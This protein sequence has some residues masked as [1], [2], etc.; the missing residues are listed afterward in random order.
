MLFGLSLGLIVALAV[1]IGRPPV[2]SADVAEPVGA[3]APAPRSS[4]PVVKQSAPAESRFD[5]YE[6]LPKF[7]VV[8]PEIET[9]AK[10]DSA[11]SA[12][13]QPGRYVL[14]AGSFSKLADADRMQASLALLGVETRIQRVTIDD[15]EFHRVRVGPISDLMELNQIRRRLR[16]ARV[17]TILIRV[18]E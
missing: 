1:Y 13:E 3:S 2:R 6:L 16:D 9:D 12:V 18:P 10:A 5:F 17:E 4:A 15:D 7:E 14:Q 8:I 11:R